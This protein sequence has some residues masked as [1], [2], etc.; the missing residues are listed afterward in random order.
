MLIH[1]YLQQEQPQQELQEKVLQ[2]LHPHHLSS[3]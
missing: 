1:L 2:S 3:S